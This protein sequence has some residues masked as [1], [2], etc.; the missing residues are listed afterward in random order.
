MEQVW[1]VAVPIEGLE[2]SCEYPMASRIVSRHYCKVVSSLYSTRGKL[3]KQALFV[4][5]AI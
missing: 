3:R 2:M 5:S 1:L 4:L